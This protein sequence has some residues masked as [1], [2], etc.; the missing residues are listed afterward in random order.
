[1]SIEVSCEKMLEDESDW[2]NSHPHSDY[3]EYRV[4]RPE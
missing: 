4:E 2:F 3:W 1:M